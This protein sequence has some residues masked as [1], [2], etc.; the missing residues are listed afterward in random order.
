MYDTPKS[1]SIFLH[2][3]NYSL[4]TRRMDVLIYYCPFLCPVGLSPE[5]KTIYFIHRTSPT[6]S[7]G[8][9]H[10][11]S[12]FR[13]EIPVYSGT[14]IY[15][16]LLSKGAPYLQFIFF[17]DVSAIIIQHYS[18]LFLW[19]RILQGLL[20]STWNR[21]HR[22]CSWKTIYQYMMGCNMYKWASENQSECSFSLKTFWYNERLL[23]K[24]FDLE[25]DRKKFS[26]TDWKNSI[27]NSKLS[28]E[29]GHW[30]KN[31]RAIGR[32]LIFCSSLRKN[33][34]GN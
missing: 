21:S 32:N 16:P 1:P 3:L 27:T 13:K 2:Y 9:P 11:P 5:R 31:M 22:H 24:I 23:N 17:K 7:I 20:L 15:R 26:K 6:V 10:H 28:R 12:S 29:P 18:E 14:E 30:V 8:S 33:E 34:L 4:R 19:L 25:P